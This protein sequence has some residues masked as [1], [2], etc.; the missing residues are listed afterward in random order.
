M[1]QDFYAAFQIGADDKH[2]TEIDQGGVA[3]A[4]I[5]GLLRLVNEKE[6]EIHAVKEHIANLERE[7]RQRDDRL[8]N[9]EEVLAE[10]RQTSRRL[11]TPAT[12]NNPKEP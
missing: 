7:S 12:S 3:L 2:I 9:L 5:Q 6:T 8:A 10:L 4:A 11:A 1:A